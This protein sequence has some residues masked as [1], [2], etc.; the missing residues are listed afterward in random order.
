MWYRH[1]CPLVVKKQPGLCHKRG[2]DELADLRAA[3]LDDEWLREHPEV[4]TQREGIAW[5]GDKMYVPDRLRRTVLLRCHDAK[6]ASH[7]GFLKILHLV[8]R[9]F[10]W[11]RLKSD[12]EKY[13]KECHVCASAKPR[14]GFS[15]LAPGSISIAQSLSR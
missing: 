1:W 7:F 11:P 4:L 2:G 13:V 6:Q 8:R 3:V 12:V 5:K 9:Q 14:T 15:S 10:W